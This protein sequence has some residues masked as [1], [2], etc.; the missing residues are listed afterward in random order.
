VTDTI[1]VDLHCHSSMSD[2]DHSPSYVAHSIAATGAVWAALTD[3]NSLEGQ[4]H[5]RQAL[6]KRGVRS[7][8]GLE[9]DA[10]SSTG[11]VHLLGYG[12][13]PQ[14]E[15]LRDA[16]RTIRQPW[17]TSL[18][19]WIATV[20][21]LRG[22]APEPTGVCMPEDEDTQHRP[23]ST[24]EAICL[25]HEAGGLVFL[26]HPLAGLGSVRRLEELLD[27]LQ[28]QGLDGLEVFHKQ[29]PPTTQ[30]DLL[31]VAERRDLLTVAGSDFHGLHHSD[32]GSPGVDMPLVHWN[33]FV[34]ALGVGEDEIPSAPRHDQAATIRGHVGH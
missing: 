27:Q 6:S 8:S 26:A 29:Y 1:R 2:G 34:T 18:R 3:H 31:A 32:G 11:P 4:D 24:T 28:P 22:Q 10:R 17:R 9:I 21:S 14:N 30:S 12:F 19:N 15:P 16:L 20:R 13:D 5:F 33:R 25:I 23:P 7:V